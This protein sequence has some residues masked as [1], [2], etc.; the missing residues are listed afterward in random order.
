MKEPLKQALIYLL[1][2]WVFSTYGYLCGAKPVDQ[3]TREEAQIFNLEASFRDY[4]SKSDDVLIKL[5]DFLYRSPVE[6]WW[7][8]TKT[9][10]R[11]LVVAMHRIENIAA[12]RAFKEWYN[13][14]PTERVALGKM[15]SLDVGY[16]LEKVLDLNEEDP[17]QKAK[18][19]FAE[20]L[21]DA[22]IGR[23][24]GL[25]DLKWRP[26]MKGVPP[27]WEEVDPLNR[28]YHRNAYTFIAMALKPGTNI[29]QLGPEIFDRHV[30]MSLL[31]YHRNSDLQI[32]DIE[33]DKLPNNP[34]VE[35][36]AQFGQREIGYEEVLTKIKAMNLYLQT[37]DDNVLGW[38]SSVE[39]KAND[40]VM[41]RVYDI[42]RKGKCFP[43]TDL[44]LN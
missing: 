33:I 30:T 20:N 24:Y 1:F 29:T 27:D 36:L 7:E 22:V 40:P 18:E 31:R 9:W 23:D 6:T 17:W 43:G 4:L 11:K 39:S 41:L 26:G 35:R 37:H 38:M 16:I 42:G 14:K 34:M 21:P 15:E 28:R 8:R 10:S 44:C 13:V 19:T 5:L 2:V 12:L 32:T 25:E 3:V